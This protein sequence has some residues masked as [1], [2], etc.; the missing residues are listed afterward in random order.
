MQRSLFE[1]LETAG[2]EICLL[3]TQYRMH[4]AISVFPRTIFYHGLLKDSDTVSLPPYSESFHSVVEPFMF[5][6][7][8]AARNTPPPGEGSDGQMQRKRGSRR[9]NLEEATAVL[10]VYEKLKQVSED[11]QGA[12]L[13]GRVGILTPYREQ[14]VL[15]KRL[16]QERGF[17]RELELNTVDGY[18]P[19]V[20]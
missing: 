8:G 7:V 16:A 2:H 15:L 14:L 10:K 6:N 12:P 13:E 5:L 18:V 20:D 4:P 17:D 19:P 11:Q 9:Y 3:D 1:R